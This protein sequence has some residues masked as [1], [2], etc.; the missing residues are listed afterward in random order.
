MGQRLRLKLGLERG[1]GLW[2]WD[3]DKGVG[4]KGAEDGKIGSG[5]GIVLRLHCCSWGGKCG[6]HIEMMLNRSLCR[7]DVSFF[8]LY[9][10]NGQ[11]RHPGSLTLSGYSE[12]TM[13]ESVSLSSLCQRSQGKTCALSCSHSLSSISDRVGLVGL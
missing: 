4:G 12:E 1:K 5:L 13:A 6:S 2:E 3:R 9:S 10:H 11:Q 8:L 7:Q